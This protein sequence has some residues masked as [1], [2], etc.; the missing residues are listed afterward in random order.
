[1]WEPTTI[2]FPSTFKATD[3]VLVLVQSDS[4]TCFH[5]PL[6]NPVPC[7]SESSVEPEGRQIP[8][9]EAPILASSLMR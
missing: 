6:D 4:H 8:V 9:S 5:H 3:N 2:G 1:M 7:L